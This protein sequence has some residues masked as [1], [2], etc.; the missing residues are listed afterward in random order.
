MIDAVHGVHQLVQRSD[1][2]GTWRGT[3]TLPLG[4]RGQPEKGRGQRGTVAGPE[5]PDQHLPAVPEDDDRA[6]GRQH[7]R[8]I[9]RHAGTAG[10]RPSSDVVRCRPD[11]R[12]GNRSATRR[13]APTQP[14][15]GQAR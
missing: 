9:H 3:E 1:A 4:L 15:S 6:T 11:H 10:C 5:R 12:S 14:A 2:E 7:R 8:R 13:A